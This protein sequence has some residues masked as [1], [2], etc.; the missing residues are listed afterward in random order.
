[1]RMKAN[2][3]PTT[4]NDDRLHTTA[5]KCP[6]A[7]NTSVGHAMNNLALIVLVELM[8]FHGGTER[9]LTMTAPHGRKIMK[10]ESN[11]VCV[12]ASEQETKRELDNFHGRLRW[13]HSLVFLEKHFPTFPDIFANT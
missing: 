5:M 1:M 13:K 11:E 3:S 7:R 10:I 4:E 12:S 8:I 9:T 2:T 6:D